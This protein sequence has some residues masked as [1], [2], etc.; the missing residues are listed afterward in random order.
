MDIKK[1]IYKEDRYCIICGKEFLVYKKRKKSTCS[2]ECLL[3]LNSSDLVNEKRKN[4][5]VKTMQNKYGVDSYFELDEFK[6]S[7]MNTKLE[8]YGSVN[9]TNLDKMK[10]TK[11]E[12]YGDQNYNNVGKNKATKLERHGDEYY[13]N[14]EKFKDT[15]INNYGG[16]GM[17]REKVIVAVNNAFRNKYG[18]NNS[19]ESDAIINKIKDA[20]IKKYGKETYL[21]SDLHKIRTWNKTLNKLNNI[22]PKIGYELL[23]DFRGTKVLLKDGKIIRNKYEFRCISCNNIFI[24]TLCDGKMPSCNICYPINCGQS[25][26]ENQIY[27]YI[28]SLIP[29]EEII[30]RD[31]SILN[32]MELDIYIPHKKI[33][34]EYNGLYWHSEINGKKDK[35]Y[36]LEKTLGCENKG[37]HL[38]HIFE[39]EWL[40]KQWIVKNKIKNLLVE[41]DEKIYARKCELREIESNIKN[42]FLDNTHILGSDK[43]CVNIGAYYNEELVSVMTF[44]KPRIAL[45][46]KGGNFYELSRF[47]TT[48]KVIGIASRLLKYFINKYTPDKIV[49][50]AS[51]CWTTNIKDNL[52]NKLGFD[53]I[54]STIP[55]YWY[56]KGNSKKNHRFMFRK[57]ILEKKLPIYDNGLTEW[58]NMQING[59][60]R[61]WDCG[62]YKFEYNIKK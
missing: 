57:N 14:R 38:I 27:E 33:A 51:R 18:V 46:Y 16:I 2:G 62:N 60:D 40:E 12:K 55:N 6:N 42:D 8:R 11:L 36:H 49:S 13:N 47:S 44:S 29:G 24:D 1:T 26:A 35:N 59:Y 20:N 17:Q 43:S 28:K 34:F 58:E 32:N 54:K 31:K 21:G 22:F 7:S 41:F 50:Y 56:F 3:K 9:Y 10:K 53:N 52:Y 15:M 48:N 19:F 39:D 5:Y 45:G 61:I 30:R 4:S 25:N 37:I 23:S